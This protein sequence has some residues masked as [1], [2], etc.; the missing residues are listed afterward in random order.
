[1]VLRL[2]Y[3]IMQSVNKLN[4]VGTFAFLNIFWVR[5]EL[6][7]YFF[8]CCVMRPPQNVDRARQA[9]KDRWTETVTICFHVTFNFLR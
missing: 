2:F 9:V 8:D 5:C 1:M 4:I 6:K 7:A 3:A